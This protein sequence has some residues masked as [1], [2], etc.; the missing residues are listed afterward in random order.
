VAAGGTLVELLG[1]RAVGLPPVDEVVASDLLARLPVSRLLDGHRGQPPA[2]VDAI[3]RAVAAMSQLAMEL[4]DWVD[5][6]D[7]NPLI[8][9]PDGA[10]AVD[11]LVV[12]R[13]PT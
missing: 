8:V 3:R 9:S 12:P 6:V 1:Q 2:D 11:V 5:A 7:V 4:G 10:I 13:D